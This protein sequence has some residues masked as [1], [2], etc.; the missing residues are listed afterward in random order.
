MFR[1]GNK[2]LFFSILAMVLFYFFFAIYSDVGQV[3]K[4]LTSMKVELIPLVLLLILAAVFVKSIRQYY[5]LKSCKI[6]IPFKKNVLI[7]ISG[8]SLIFT[9]G[10]IGG[11]VKTKFF[12]DNHGVSIRNTVPIVIMELYHEFLGLVVIIGITI[13]FYGFIEAKIAFVIGSVFFI[14]T[15]AVFRYQ[16]AFL[17]FSKFLNKINMFR[18]ISEGG[19]ESQKNVHILTSPTKMLASS[20]IT[21]FSMIFDLAAVYLIF[22]AFDANKLNFILESQSYLTAFLLGQLSFLPNGIGVT[23][24]SFIGILVSRKL[25]LAVATSAVLSIRFIN[26]WARTGM[27]LIVLRFFVNKK[28]LNNDDKNIKTE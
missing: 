28:N 4:S 21:I 12:K 27:G 11:V 24:I 2:V 8:L 9:P 3:I 23:D 6:N 14:L 1:I 17:T 18:K 13:L 16:K 26:L 5:L 22:L 10:G 15:Y 19:E 25:D 7:Y 20:S